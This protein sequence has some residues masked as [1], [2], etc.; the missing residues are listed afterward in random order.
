MRLRDKSIMHETDYLSRASLLISTNID[1]IDIY[2][3]QSRTNGPINAH[4]TIAQV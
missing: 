3:N 4:L 2:F 1:L